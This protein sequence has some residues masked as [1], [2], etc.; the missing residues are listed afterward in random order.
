MKGR[1]DLKA[2]STLQFSQMH[3]TMGAIL[4]EE[5]QKLI[6]SLVIGGRLPHFRPKPL[7]SIGL[8]PCQA[9]GI[10]HTPS[11][12]HSV[13]AFCVNFDAVNCWIIVDDVNCKKPQ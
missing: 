9:R 7:S 10:L 12:V 3:A 11:E 6:V 5:P 8:W 1:A 2:R 13:I 4:S